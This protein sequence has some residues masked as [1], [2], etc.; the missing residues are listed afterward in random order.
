MVFIIDDLAQIV[1]GALVEY[2]N[3]SYL[4]SLQ[5]YLRELRLLYETG[6]IDEASYRRRETQVTMTIKT[7]RGQQKYQ[8][9]RAVDVN[10]F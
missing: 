5:D 6:Q 3:D 2:V 4:K 9:P 8:S 10:L 7:L 1:I